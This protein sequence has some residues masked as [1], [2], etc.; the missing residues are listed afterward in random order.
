QRVLKATISTLGTLKDLTREALELGVEFLDLVPVPGLAP[1]AR[2]VLDVWDAVQ[3]VDMNRLASLRL[4]ERCADILLSVRLEV[5][6]AGDVVG[7][8]LSGPLQRL[9]QSFKQVLEFLQ[10]NKRRPL[11]K[12]Y[13]K[14][15]EILQEISGLDTNLRDA[16]G[17][18]GLSVQIRILKQVQESE[19]QRQ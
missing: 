6:E 3:E 16:L 18:F 13:L 14:R 9:E 4:A 17:M 12:R 2:L 1:A 8:E 19:K 5:K 11:L 15:D 10:K 7:E